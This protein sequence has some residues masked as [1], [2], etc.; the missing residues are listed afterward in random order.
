M[1]KIAML[2]A[3]FAAAPAAAQD[4][5]AS[6]NGPWVAAVVGYE[7]D[8][9]DIEGIDEGDFDTSVDDVA[10][11]VALGYDYDAGMAVIGAEAELSDSEVEANVFDLAR[12]E[13]GRD[14]YVGLRAGAKLNPNAMIYAK[15][16]YSNL[17][18]KAD[19]GVIE[20]SD[21]FDGYRIG[22]GAEYAS[23]QLFGRLEYRY[24]QYDLNIDGFEEDSG[25]DLE[26]HQVMVMGGFRF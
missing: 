11:G 18:L 2:A 15:G 6:F 5:D 26:R 25:L 19:D 14:I 8:S 3:A 1:K 23:G 13:T 12:I 20:D 21:E 16:G 7:S 17:S 4:A 9:L 10:Y 22:A 24:S